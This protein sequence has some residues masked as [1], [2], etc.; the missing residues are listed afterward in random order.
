MNSF[1]TLPA[2]LFFLPSFLFL[3]IIAQKTFTDSTFLPNHSDPVCIF[4]SGPKDGRLLFCQNRVGTASL[5]VTCGK[6]AKSPDFAGIKYNI[7][8]FS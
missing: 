7:I 5:I 2:I 3:L 4:N 1:Q 8:L 6:A